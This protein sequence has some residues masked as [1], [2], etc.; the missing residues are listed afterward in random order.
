GVAGLR[1]ADPDDLAGRLLLGGDQPRVAAELLAALEATDG[2]DLQENGQPDDPADPG[3]GLQH[4]QL[5]RVVLRGGNF[6]VAFESA[7]LG[8]QRPEQVEPR[9]DSTPG[10]LIG[11]VGGHVVTRALVLHVASNGFEVELP[12][13][14]VDVSVEFGPLPDQ[15]QPGAEQVTHCASFVGVGV[16]E[17]EG[18]APQ[19]PGDG[20]GV[21]SVALC[22]RPVDGPHGPGV[23]EGEGDAVFAAGVGEPVPGVDALAPDQQVRAERLDRPEE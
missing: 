8:V 21:L 9:L 20:L 4:R 11:D 15:P 19:E 23:S 18:A 5:A 12:T 6:D 2:V 17:G 10:V 1:V 22:V 16:G 14:G 7:D 3:D 13:G